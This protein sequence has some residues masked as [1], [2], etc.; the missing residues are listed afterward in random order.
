MYHLLS[1]MLLFMTQ[2]QTRNLDPEKPKHLSPQISDDRDRKDVQSWT[3]I[4]LPSPLRILYVW[5]VRCMLARLTI[6][7][8]D[9]ILRALACHFQLSK[10][11]QLPSLHPP[12]SSSEFLRS[13]LGLRSGYTHAQFRS[14]ALPQHLHFGLWVSMGRQA[15]CRATERICSLQLCSFLEINLSNIRR[16]ENGIVYLMTDF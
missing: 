13:T 14:T 8:S 9:H 11:A 15:S 4:M 2:T 3:F 16:R 1:E 12:L 10:V 6:L 5:C 7:H